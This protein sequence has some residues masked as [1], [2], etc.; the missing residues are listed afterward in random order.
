M[1][2]LLVDAEGALAEAAPGG[3]ADAVIHI[4]AVCL[5]LDATGNLLAHVL[6][7]EVVVG[8]M[9]LNFRG[10]IRRLRPEIAGTAQMEVGILLPDRL[11][12]LQM[13][14]HLGEIKYPGEIDVVVLRNGVVVLQQ[15]DVVPQFLLITADLHKGQI[16]VTGPVVQQIRVNNA[17]FFCHGFHRPSEP[18]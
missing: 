18:V 10:E 7:I 16:G 15:G 6:V 12:I 5:R 3:E 8:H 1:V 14:G 17:D 4:V 11:R 13:V 9:V 2:I